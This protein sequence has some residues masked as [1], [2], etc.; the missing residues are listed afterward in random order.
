MLQLQLEMFP[1]VPKLPKGYRNLWSAGARIT[2][3]ADL[4]PVEMV[5]TARCFIVDNAKV[6]SDGMSRIARFPES[7]K[8]RVVGVSAGS[9][10]QHSLREER[11]TPHR[12]K[13]TCVEISRMQ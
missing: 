8:L 2:G 6:G 5:A 3:T 1:L 11:F 12:D 13:A 4:P 10:S 7:Q 9:A